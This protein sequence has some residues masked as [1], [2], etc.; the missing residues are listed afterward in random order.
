MASPILPDSTSFWIPAGHTQPRAAPSVP[1]QRS[2]S[3]HTHT[4]L[5]F[6]SCPRN[7][8]GG[9]LQNLPPGEPQFEESNSDLVLRQLLSQ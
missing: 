9:E 1:T 2:K 4:Q 6:S 7:K 8:N 3:H 5:F